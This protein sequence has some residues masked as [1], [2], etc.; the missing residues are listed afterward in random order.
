MVR[1]ERSEGTAVARA[2]GKLYLFGIQRP[3]DMGMLS[4]MRYST[5]S[6]EKEFAVAAESTLFAQCVAEVTMG[7]RP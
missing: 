2:R 4:V 3:V 7:A 6:Q 1:C 5:F